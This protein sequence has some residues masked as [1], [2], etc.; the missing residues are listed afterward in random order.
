MVAAAGVEPD[1]SL[2][3][4]WWRCATLAPKPKRDKGFNSNLL[5]S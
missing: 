3:A 1:P 4:K 2:F 5:S